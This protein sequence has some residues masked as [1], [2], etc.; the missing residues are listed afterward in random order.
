MDTAVRRRHAARRA[1]IA[2]ALIPVGFILA[3]VLGEG[4]LSAYGYGTGEGDPP[5]WAVLAAAGPAL[6]VF[7]IPCAA[8]WVLGRR[9]AAAGE[10]NGTLPAWIGAVVGVLFVL[11]NLL[12][13]V[14]GTVLD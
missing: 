3:L 5:F 9:A 10:P 2:V 14:L 7:A 12:A 4:L 11:Q 8:A 1:W 13:Y 6:V